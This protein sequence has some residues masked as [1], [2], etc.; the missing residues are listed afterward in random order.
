[1]KIIFQKLQTD[2]VAICL[3]Y[4]ENKVNEIFIYWSYESEIYLKRKLLEG[5][6][7]IPSRSFILF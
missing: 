7:V 6:R 1:M 5:N 4:V 3:E 2:M